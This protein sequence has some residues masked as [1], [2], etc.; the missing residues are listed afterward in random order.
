MIKKKDNLEYEFLPA[1]LEIIETP[2][3]PV[4]KLIVWI[5][6]AIF[7]SAILWSY[8][9]TVDEVAVA[10]G[11]LVPDGRLKVIQPVEEGVVQAIYIKEGERVKK[12][13]L[14]VELDST[15]KE[16]DVDALK[17]KL[18]VTKV[19]KE[20]LKSELAGVSI[21]SVMSKFKEELKE[22][23]IDDRQNLYSLNRARNTEYMEKSESLKLAITQKE[24]ENSIANTNLVKLENRYSQLKEEES[25]LKYLYDIGSIPK[26]KWLDKKNELMAAEK[27]YEA[28]KD[29]A[30]QSKDSIEEAK[31]SLKN[32]EKERET[33]ILNQIVEKDKMISELE[34]SLAKAK[35]SYDLQKLVSPVDG[36]VNGLSLST[37]G[38]V[39]T[40]AQ[41]IMT[42]VPD[43]TPLTVEASVLNKDIGF[44]KVGQKTELKL[45]TF[46]FQKY[47][48]INGVVTAIS[49]DAFEDEKIGLI[50]KIKIEPERE[51]I[52]ANGKKVNLTAGMSLNAEIKT[53]KRRIIEFFLSPVMQS[54][55]ESLKLR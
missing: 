7:A 38:G 55:D 32:Y 51:Y 4:G 30:V 48:T 25:S 41:P 36:V 11:K 17:S 8:L 3:S 20:I 49:P 2:P 28:Q 50:Y 15:M 5:I 42:I 13:E 10:R 34:S 39:V 46:P 35:K 45:D 16:T 18:A 37:I 22:I 26:R 1:A 47:G 21:D 19:E 9:G 29:I 12:G 53:G 43:N 24:T 6:F 23:G 33:N 31:K 44:V 54:L 40:P 27:E 52:M 14:L